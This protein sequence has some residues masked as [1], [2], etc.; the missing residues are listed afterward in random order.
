M[1]AAFYHHLGLGDHF[2][3][4]GY[5]SEICKSKKYDEIHITSFPHYIPVL[6]RL[7]SIITNTGIKVVFKEVSNHNE[8]VNYVQS[9]D[10]DKHCCWWYGFTGDDIIENLCYS[11][12]GVP[13]SKRYSNFREAVIFA[14][15]E[16]K[17]SRIFK[18]LVGD[19]QNYIFV[20]DDPL[21]GY[22]IDKS[23]FPNDCKIIKSCNYL[24][25]DPIDLLKVMELSKQYHCMYSSFFFFFDQYKDD[26]TSSGSEIHLHES[27]VK[28]VFTNSRHQSFFSTRNIKYH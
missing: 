6:K 4:F 5:I 26:I 27:Y 12:K 24:H 14:R 1:R 3:H 9:F 7:Y 20:A 15:D 16:E 10:G 18:E 28:I 13:S 21:R 8:G 22:N 11:L 19:D 2:I 23:F 25:Y 17:E